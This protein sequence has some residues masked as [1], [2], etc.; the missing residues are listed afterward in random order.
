MALPTRATR[1]AGGVDTDAVVTVVRRHGPAFAGWLL[2]FLLVLYLALKEGGY[3]AAIRSEVG[4]AVWWIVLV[5]AAV[6]ALPAARIPRVGWTGLGLLAA[7]ALWTGL[8]IGWSESAERSVAELGRVATLLGIFALALSVQGREA[9]RRTTAAIVAATGVVAVLALVSRMEPTWIPAEDYLAFLPGAANR[10]AFPLGYWNGLGQLIA[11]GL[12]LA[13]WMA[14]EGRLTVTRALATAAIPAMSLTIFLTLSRGGIGA[15]LI[16]LL[17]LIGLHPRRVRLILPLALG[18]AGSALVIAA[19][20]QRTAFRDG[21]TNSVASSQGAEMLA[22]TLVVCGAVGLLA[23]AIALADKHGLGPRLPRPSRL[24]TGVTAAV[25]AI[26]V[27]VAA[28]AAGGPGEISDRWE[29]F[30]E[31]ATSGGVERLGSLTGSSRYQFWQSAI[32]ANASE[33]WRGIGPGTYEFWFARDVDQ[34]AA[35]GLFVRDAHSLYLETLAELGIIGFVLIVGFVGFVLVTG[36]VR[37]FRLDKS[38]PMAALLA[39]ATAGAVAFAVAA[40]VDWAW[41]MTIL[42]VCFLLLAAV[43][44][45]RDTGPESDRD[46]EPETGR[47]RFVPRGVLA[48]LAVAALIAVAIPYAGVTSVDESQA[49]VRSRALENALAD[50]R[51]ASDVQPYA[52]SPY[53]QQALVFELGGDYDAAAAAA[54][55]ATEEEP[56]NWR[57]WFV[58]SRIEAE[59]GDPK[60]AVTAFNEARSLNPKS[61][62]FSQP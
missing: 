27:L 2:P 47:V 34:E 1:S 25:L 59:R 22:M 42:P 31:P 56:T 4:I 41:E 32:D 43:I 17:V 46:L 16:A 53:M 57:N 36:A 23:A 54:T 39:A 26:V 9:A 18:A 45:G 61:L 10:L 12:P 35:M 29:E 55:Q 3:D 11:I 40:A 8:G 24:I 21:L 49:D 28:L 15:A 48:G 37:A 44:L 6:G 52:A 20:T 7:F 38:E 30:K 51:T 60:A 58:L 33:P 13:V 19:A 5:G 14:A 62:L 50:A